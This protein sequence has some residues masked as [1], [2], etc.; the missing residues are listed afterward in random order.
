MYTMLQLRNV[1]NLAVVV[2]RCV[3]KCRQDGHSLRITSAFSNTPAHLVYGDAVHGKENVTNVMWPVV[4]C[5][6]MQ[7]IAL[8]VLL[9]HCVCYLNFFLFFFPL[10]FYGE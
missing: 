5:L 10:P 7:C 1:V 2:N 9:L 8:L 4:V 3:Q 6:H